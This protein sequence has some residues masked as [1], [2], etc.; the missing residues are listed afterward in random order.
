MMLR[1]YLEQWLRSPRAALV[2]LPLFAGL[3]TG[4]LIMSFDWSLGAKVALGVGVGGMLL[5]AYI[6]AV[7]MY[8]VPRTHIV[9]IIGFPGSGKTTLITS[10]FRESFAMH[11]SGYKM[12]PRGKQCIDRVNAHLRTLDMGYAL[13]PTADQERFSFR[14]DIVRRGLGL[15]RTYRTEFGDFPGDDSETY[16]RMHGEWL[17]TTEFFQWVSDSDALVFVIDLARYI[18]TPNEYVASMA[19][20]VRAAWQHY[21]EA[22]RHRIGRVRLQPVVLAFTKADLFGV[23]RELDDSDFR[24]EWIREHGFGELAPP[25][26]ELDEEVLKE[27][28]LL[29]Q[30]AFAGLIMYLQEETSRFRVIFTSCFG[31][32][33]GKLLGIEE[34][35]DAVLPH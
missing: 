24:N 8:M 28:R 34:L 25:L 29:A 2:L 15:A 5:S 3:L 11:L 4:L 35:I 16:A 10:L 19:A 23:M 14:A 26:A 1:A 27:G 18:E 9:G 13:G 33:D 6:F 31:S 12:T 22:N 20:A 21:V 32:L 7:G 17:H 30:N